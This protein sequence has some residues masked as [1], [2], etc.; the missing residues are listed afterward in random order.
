MSFTFKFSQ[1]NKL[2]LDY[3]DSPY[4]LNGNSGEGGVGFKNEKAVLTGIEDRNRNLF[5]NYFNP[6]SVLH[7]FLSS[8]NR[9]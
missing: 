5:F 4:S 2:F 7:I 6:V 3:L 8:K 1:H 9:G